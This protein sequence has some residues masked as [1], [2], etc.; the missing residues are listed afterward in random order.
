M[1]DNEKVLVGLI[2]LSICCSLVGLFFSKDN[3]FKTGLKMMVGG[4][5]FGSVIAYVIHD[6][7]FSEWLKRLA[8]LLSSMFAKP[9]YDKVSDRIGHWLDKW[10]ITKINKQENEVPP[11][12]ETNTYDNNE[13]K[14]GTSD[15]SI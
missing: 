8:T 5:F 2:I 10:I 13:H 3:D 15:G 6:S 7:S 1:T 11:S 4:F 14:N 9:L 12:T